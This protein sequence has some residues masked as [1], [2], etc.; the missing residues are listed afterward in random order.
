MKALIKKSSLNFGSEPTAYKSV[1]HDAMEY[2]ADPEE[3]LK[4]KEDTHAMAAN[5][6]RY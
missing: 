1:A 4:S 3:Y 6:R 5:L 2:R